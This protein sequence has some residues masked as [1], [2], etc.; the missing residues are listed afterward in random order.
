MISCVGQK[1]E[2]RRSKLVT[3]PLAFD[4]VRDVSSLSIPKSSSLRFPT[5]NLLMIATVLVGSVAIVFAVI[6]LLRRR[7]H[8]HSNLATERLGPVSEQW[9]TAH[10]GER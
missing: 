7:P 3:K 6:R 9:L 4:P 10:R 1:A 2:T 5:M 8:V